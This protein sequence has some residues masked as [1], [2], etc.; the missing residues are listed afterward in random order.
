MNT[1]TKSGGIKDNY[2]KNQLRYGRLHQIDVLSRLNIYEINTK[3]FD[4]N[5]FVLLANISCRPEAQP[6]DLLLEIMFKEK[7]NTSYYRFQI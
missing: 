3:K 5:L 4:H 6:K 2:K 7:T 1:S